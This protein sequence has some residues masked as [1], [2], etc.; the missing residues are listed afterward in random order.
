M[1][2][3]INVRNQ[4]KSHERNSSD[5]N[6][7]END[8]DILASVQM[9][10]LGNTIKCDYM[11]SRGIC[12]SELD[13]T[14]FSGALNEAI[15]IRDNITDVNQ[16]SS[17]AT[18]YDIDQ[19]ASLYETVLSQL[20]TEKNTFW[21]FTFLDQSI[22]KLNLYIEKTKKN[23]LLIT[24]SS[25]SNNISAINKI[26]LSLHSRLKHKGWVSK[27]DQQQNTQ[28]DDEFPVTK[29]EEDK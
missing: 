5:E 10:P 20:K 14:E 21:K 11:M 6:I 7:N 28:L 15:I 3:K 16:L 1:D 19:L 24:L 26:I 12:T 2:S 8:E 13:E 9:N 29:E 25:A 23:N 22:T 18:A 4:I 17:Y 27:I